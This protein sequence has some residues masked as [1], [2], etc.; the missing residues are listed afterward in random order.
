MGFVSHI[1]ET[2]QY[3]REHGWAEYRK[4]RQRYDRH[5]KSQDDRVTKRD[6]LDFRKQV[7]KMQK[8]K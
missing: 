1:I 6:R 3:I 7:K 4:A 2:I 8:G 5:I